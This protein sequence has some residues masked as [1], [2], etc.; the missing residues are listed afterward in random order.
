M[1]YHL[2]SN[3]LKQLLRITIISSVGLYISYHAISGINHEDLFDLEENI[4]YAVVAAFTFLAIA[5]LDN[6]QFS[7]TG[8]RSSFLATFIGLTIFVGYLIVLSSF[9][10]SDNSP[11]QIYCVTKYNDFNGVSIDFRKDGTY[12]LTIWSLG[13]DV[14]RGKYTIKDSIITIDKSKIESCIV[15]NRFVIR[16]DGE[17]DRDGKQEKSIYQIDQKGQVINRS[18]D[19]RIIE[20][21]NQARVQ[22]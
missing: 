13:T 9:K 17:I 22:Y 14:Y 5:L 12:K 1:L 15:S 18:I 4:F 6:Q 2:T 20:D 21:T 8:K 10:Q 3:N 19:F 16:Q 7:E 11:S